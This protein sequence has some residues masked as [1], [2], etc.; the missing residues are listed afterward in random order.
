MKVTA[1]AGG[2]GGAKLLQGLAQVLA[3]DLTA[4][5]NTADD[6]T[7]YGVHV[8]PDLDIVTYWL[9]GVADEERGWG[10]AGDTFEVVGALR[11]LGED[12][13]FSLGDRDFGTCIRRTQRLGQGASLSVITDEIRRAYGVP[14]VILPMSDDPVRTHLELADG[15]TLEFQEYFVKQ[16]HQPDVRTVFFAGLE[17]AKPAPGV[18]DALVGADRVV[19]CPSNP[20]VSVAPILALPGVRDALRTHARVLAVSPIVG[21]RALKGP[22]DRLLAS[23]EGG[24]GA[25]AV[26]KLYSDF[27]DVFVVDL[28]DREELA[29]AAAAGVRAVTRDTIMRDREASEALA[30][31]LLEL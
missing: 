24:R 7:A 30:R 16:R 2:V 19:V 20:F 21:G 17:E 26:G 23:L 10:I 4:V 11:E 12:A 15:R 3:G 29:V 9:A 8:S 28:G 27:V 22:A 25:G 6:H 13:W 31:A 5:V 14:T 18:L 1:L